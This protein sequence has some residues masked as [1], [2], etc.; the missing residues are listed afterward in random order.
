VDVIFLIDRVDV[1]SSV[2]H[3]D[4]DMLMVSAADINELGARILPEFF[5]NFANHR[6][7][8]PG[9]FGSVLNVVT[10]HDAETARDR[11][12]GNPEMHMGTAVA[13]LV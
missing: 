9:P 12:R 13:V 1:D 2:V 11:G 7:V 10:R 5:G 3:G 6:K 4:S 8:G